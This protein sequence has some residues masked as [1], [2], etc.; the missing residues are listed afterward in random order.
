MGNLLGNFFNSST[1][2]SNVFEPCSVGPTEPVSTTFVNVS[3][4]AAAAAAVAAGAPPAAG[5]GA[6]VA[7]GAPTSS[8]AR[9][10]LRSDSITAAG[11][12]PSAT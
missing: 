10:S 2:V 6:A 8:A 4:A 12:E 3:S 7:A 11:I 9:F 5:A 1:K